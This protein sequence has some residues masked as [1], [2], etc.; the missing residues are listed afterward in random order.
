MIIKELELIHFGQFH[1]KKIRLD[2]GVNLIYGEN[3]SGKT[4]IWHF[5]LGMFYGFFKPYIKTRRYL[6]LHEKYKPWQSSQY[7]GSMVI[8]DEEMKRELHIYRNFFQ[9]EEEVRVHDYITGEELTP[10]YDLHP[11][12]R[13]PDI[14]KKHL[15]L[16]YSGYMNMGAIGQMS[17][18]TDAMLAVELKELVVNALSSKTLNVSMNKI[19]QHIQQKK[20]EIGS[21]RKKKSLYGLNLEKQKEYQQQRQF[22]CD[23]ERALQELMMQRR[24]LETEVEELREKIDG[25]TLY[26]QMRE[27]E[28]ERERQTKRYRVR[29]EK[30]RLQKQMKDVMGNGN[31]TLEEV[32]RGKEAYNE[33]VRLA[34]GLQQ[35]E[36][37]RLAW[38]KDQEHIEASIKTIEERRIS[39]EN[40]EKNARKNKGMLIGSFFLLCLFFISVFM[41]NLWLT[42]IM[43]T[44]FLA[45]GI[46]FLKVYKQNI[47]KSQQNQ[48]CEKELNELKAEK[49]LLE[50]HI[51]E[52]QKKY[53]MHQQQRMENREKYMPMATLLGIKNA[54]DFE[55]CI[56]GYQKA[57]KMKGQLIRLEEQEKSIE[58]NQNGHLVE[59]RVL[60]AWK[61]KLDSYE[62]EHVRQ[63]KQSKQE[64]LEQ[65]QQSEHEHIRINA[66]IQESKKHYKSVTEIDEAIDEL[67]AQQQ[68]FDAKQHI[69]GIVEETL[70]GI[71]N[72]LKQEFAPEMNQRIS[73]LV[74]MITDGKYE[75]IKIT[76]EMNILFRNSAT[77]RLEDV[78]A[79]SQGT[80][81][82]FYISF[83]YVLTKW[84][85]GNQTIPLVFDEVFAYFDD[86]RLERVM[87]VVKS[88]DEQI[89]LFT[90]QEREWNCGIDKGMHGIK[91]Q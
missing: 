7:C 15:N 87:D 50:V 68:R 26:E 75:E 28:E 90:C 57:E 1:H 89:L 33:E 48:L 70:E 34:K 21:K 60:E 40:R 22:S 85:Q 11:I 77:G 83:R 25:I 12:F 10:L 9:G 44:I 73:Q 82:L 4:T 58:E 43:F 84:Q 55:R 81:D 3:E 78:T 66:K 2:P 13:L 54:S 41:Q 39:G 36:K 86:W 24:C 17:H 46:L 16:S 18:E 67:K 69:Y 8:Y 91:L 64:I 65:L 37:E 63:W 47:E 88:F 76:S 30:E 71:T 56:Q 79:L 14:A 51:Q 52:N 35:M 5:V 49:H 53:R 45:T 31:Y 6:D 59:D 27:Q 80:M 62:M 74:A 38:Q 20:E 72:T 42:F 29:Q 23:Q 19:Q 32:Y 61:E